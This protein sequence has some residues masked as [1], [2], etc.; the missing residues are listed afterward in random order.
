MRSPVYNLKA[1]VLALMLLWLPVG[2]QAQITARE[3]TERAVQVHGGE[4]V[5]AVRTEVNG[6]PVW[7]LRIVSGDRVLDVLVDA[8]TGEVLQGAPE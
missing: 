7:H 4:V 2:A 3:A 5:R 8:Q 1:A 6:R